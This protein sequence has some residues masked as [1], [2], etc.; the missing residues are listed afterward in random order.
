M[1]MLNVVI[2]VGTLKSSSEISNTHLLSEFL[3]KHLTTYE[4]KK[5]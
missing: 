4:T 2:L 3:A 1:P 5:L